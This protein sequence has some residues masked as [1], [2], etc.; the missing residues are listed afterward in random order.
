VRRKIALAG[1]GLAAVA[2][3]APLPAASAVCGPD[4]SAVGGPSC[5]NLCPGLVVRVVN[6]VVGDGFLACLA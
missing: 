4:L 5:P 1:V 3:L 2:S 6:D